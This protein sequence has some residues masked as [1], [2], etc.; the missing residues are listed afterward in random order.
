MSSLPLTDSD[1]MLIHRYGDVV[2]E[3]H[4]VRG[5]VPTQT[6]KEKISK[7]LE[8]CDPESTKVLF[9]PAVKLV[10][11]DSELDAESLAT[12]LGDTIERF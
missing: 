7:V 12:L 2:H 9:C 4:V 6:L 5:P 11:F 3:I 8:G 10:V 1:W